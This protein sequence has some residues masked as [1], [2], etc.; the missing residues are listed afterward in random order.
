M[1]DLADCIIR[2]LSATEFPQYEIYNVGSGTGVSVLEVI[3]LFK[4]EKNISIKY[5]IRPRREADVE[6]LIA[7]PRKILD[8]YNWKT[9]TT[10]REIINS[11]PD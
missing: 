10:L 8:I 5:T 7:D 6:Q 1:G 9:S 2:I 4:S 3:E 11:L